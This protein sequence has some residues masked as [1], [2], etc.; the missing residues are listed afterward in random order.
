M[1]KNKKIKTFPCEECVKGKMKW[2]KKWRYF[3]CDV[4]GSLD[5]DATICPKCKTIVK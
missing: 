5:L 1:K 4:C 2:I 3:Q